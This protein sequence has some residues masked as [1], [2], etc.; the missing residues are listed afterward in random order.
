MVG[1]GRFSTLLIP[2]IPKLKQSFSL[3]Y[4]LIFVFA[5]ILGVIGSYMLRE[6]VDIPPPEMIEELKMKDEEDDFGIN[7]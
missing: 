7:N 5:G 3:S 1:V 2:F 6:T 4:D